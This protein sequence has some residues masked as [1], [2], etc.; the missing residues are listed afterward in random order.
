MIHHRKDSK[1]ENMKIYA[2]ID[3][4]VFVQLK[5]YLRIFEP[6]KQ[7]ALYP[8]IK[9]KSKQ[10][11][12]LTPKNILYRPNNRIYLKIKKYIWKNNFIKLNF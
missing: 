1:Y 3:I 2:L 11:E 8:K 5:A 4:V 6:S 9:W 7:L 12:I 10:I